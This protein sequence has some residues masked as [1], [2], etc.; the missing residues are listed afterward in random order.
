VGPLPKS[1]NAFRIVLLVLAL[2]IIWVCFQLGTHRHTG[3][4]RTL[5]RVRQFVSN[6]SSSADKIPPRSALP[7]PRHS[8]NLSWKASASAVLGYNVY[9]RDRSGFSKINSVPVI[10]TSYVDSSVQPGLTYYY[11]TR[12]V[13]ST[14]TE[15][16]PSN[17][18]RVVVPSP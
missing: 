16:S 7:G 8:V 4:L 2:A 5:A 12:A 6:T 11:I 13:S 14:G 10:G 9:R 18:I 15:S 3:I 17:E 1:K